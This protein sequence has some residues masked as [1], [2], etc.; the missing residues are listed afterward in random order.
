MIFGL[1]PAKARSKIYSTGTGLINRVMADKPFIVN[2][3]E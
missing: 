2:A 3:L 1:A